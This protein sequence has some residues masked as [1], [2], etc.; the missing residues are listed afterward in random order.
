MSEKINILDVEIDELTAKEALRE[1]IRYMESEPISIIEMVTVDALMRISKVQNLIEDVR[2]FDLMLAG[3][4]TILEAADV[5]E[6]K[7]LQET[8]NRTYLK[9]FTRYLHKNHKR[10]YLLV[11][12]G[13]EGEK[14]Y[15]YFEERYSGIQIAGLAKVSANDRADDM[16]VNDI[17]GSEVDCV[18][19]ALSAPLQ[20]E[21]IV[22]NK[23][24]LNAR[25]WLGIGR[26]ILPMKGQSSGRDKFTRFVEKHIFKKEIE[27]RKRIDQICAAK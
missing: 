1:S 2:F 6:R 17:N 15:Q 20:E 26:D 13:E 3:D 14:L 19:S 25:V 21:F 9:L 24:V 12:S 18:L 23:G 4:K 5:M 22:K 11:E 8:E 27:K 10:V 16:L 7:I